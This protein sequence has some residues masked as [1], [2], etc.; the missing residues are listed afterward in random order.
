VVYVTRGLLTALLELAADRNPESVTVA[1]LTTPAAEFETDLPA[2]ASVFTDMYLPD[3]G[4][5]ITAVFGMDISTPGANG[6]FVSHPDGPL[7]LTKTDDLHEVVFVAVPPYEPDAVG[8]FDRSGSELPV[9][10]VEAAPPPGTL[11][12]YS[13]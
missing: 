11:E 10:V 5:S 13:R 12:D 1:L 4:R 9:E 8:A 3:S 6:R 7:A 2:D